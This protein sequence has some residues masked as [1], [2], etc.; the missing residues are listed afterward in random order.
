MVVLQKAIEDRKL[1]EEGINYATTPKISAMKLTRL[2]ND[3][4]SD[5]RVNY[6]SLRSHPRKDA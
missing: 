4:Y 3:D 6:S 1:L 2:S 5:R